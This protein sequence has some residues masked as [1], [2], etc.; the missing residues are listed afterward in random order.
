M[1]NQNRTLVG[2]F[3]TRLGLSYNADRFAL[4][5]NRRAKFYKFS[6]VI[7]WGEP[8]TAAGANRKCASWARRK[9]SEHS[10]GGLLNFDRPPEAHQKST[11]NGQH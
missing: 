3:H 2:N 1:A 8:N 5:T 6:Q 7:R 11:K 4:Y 9:G 10:T